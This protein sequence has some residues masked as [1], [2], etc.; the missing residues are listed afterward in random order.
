MTYPTPTLCEELIIDDG[1]EVV[2]YQIECECPLELG[3]ARTFERLTG[4][5]LKVNTILEEDMRKMVSFLV[6]NGRSFS[7]AFAKALHVEV[8]R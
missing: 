6:V 8:G 3:G 7:Y 4:G 2:Q 1:Y 5:R